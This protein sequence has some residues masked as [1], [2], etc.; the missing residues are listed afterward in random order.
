MIT[1]TC[2]IQRNKTKEWKVSKWKTILDL[3]TENDKGGTKW[4]YD[5]DDWTLVKGLEYF[6]GREAR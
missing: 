6:G 4:K 2:G 1:S 3:K 5:D